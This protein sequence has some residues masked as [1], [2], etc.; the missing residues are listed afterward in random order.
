MKKELSLRGCSLFEFSIQ[1]QPLQVQMSYGVAMRARSC[2]HLSAEERKGVSL[3][4]AMA[5]RSEQWRQW[6]GVFRVLSSEAPLRLPE[7]ITAAAH[8]K[9]LTCGCGSPSN[10]I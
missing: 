4:C 3:G 2:R 7:L 10:H 9:S 5:T 8:G 6:W 1:V